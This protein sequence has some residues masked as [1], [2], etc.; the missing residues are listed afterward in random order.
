MSQSIDNTADRRILRTRQALDSAFIALLMERE[1]D[2]IRVQDICDRANVGRSTFYNHYV[3]KEGLLVGG[4]D[5]LGKHIRVAHGNQP[6]GTALWFAR[7]IIEHVSENSRVFGA[8]VGK[9]SGELVLARFR[10]LSV[11][12]ARDC[13]KAQGIKDPLLQA[14]AHY[15]GGAF[16]ELLGWWLQSRQR[17]SS[18][19]LEQMFLAMSAAVLPSALPRV[20]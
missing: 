2:D 5:D 15:L 8:I 11:D 12:L 9:R 19:A 4:L 7:G 3:D 10:Q 13:L 16:V 17:I 6:S 14:S 18:E 20:D 1:W